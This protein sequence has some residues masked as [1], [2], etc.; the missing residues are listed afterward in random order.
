MIILDGTNMHY[1]NGNLA[2]PSC[3]FLLQNYHTRNIKCPLS[4]CVNNAFRR[5]QESR[6]IKT[7]LLKKYPC[8]SVQQH[9][10]SGPAKSK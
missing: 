6:R 2:M 3:C 9:F 8:T 1:V 7:L 4:V 5:F 10:Y